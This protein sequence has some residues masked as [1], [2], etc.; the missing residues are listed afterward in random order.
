MGM[1]QSLVVNISAALLEEVVVGCGGRVG[2]GWF[3]LL[4][5]RYWHCGEAVILNMWDREG[6]RAICLTDGIAGRNMRWRR[7]QVDGRTTRMT[8]GTPGGIT[9]THFA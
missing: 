2:K 9:Q 8:Y 7:R 6:K 3:V 4:W 1:W 5:K